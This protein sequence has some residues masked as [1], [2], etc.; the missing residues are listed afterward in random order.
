MPRESYDN[1]HVIDVVGIGAE[2]MGHFAAVAFMAATAA[3]LFY[4]P[5]R[6]VA[7]LGIA[8]AV[9]RLGTAVLELATNSDW[10]DAVVALGF[11]SF[12]GWTFAASVTLALTLRR[13]Y[14]SENSA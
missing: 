13:G 7:W 8:L 4:T 3:A 12:L 14:M 1:A 11:L 6:K 2:H 5:A 10:S 9:F